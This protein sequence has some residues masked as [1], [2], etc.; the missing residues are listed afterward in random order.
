MGSVSRKKAADRSDFI[1]DVLV[2]IGGAFS[3]KSNVGKVIGN[4][5]N[6]AGE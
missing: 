2:A 3:E 1:N 4:L 5:R 6:I